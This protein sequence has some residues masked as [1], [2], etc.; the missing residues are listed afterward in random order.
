MENQTIQLL[1]THTMSF[2]RVGG[3]LS[4]KSIHNP[5][6]SFLDIHTMSYTCADEILERYRHFKI[7]KSKRTTVGHTY[8]VICFP[9][10]CFECLKITNAPIWQATG[11]SM[12]VQKHVL[13]TKFEATTKN[14]NTVFGH[15][16]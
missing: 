12:Y 15:I 3:T 10:V 7:K 2:E 13:E 16:Q 5:E 6:N 1:D 9:L 14:P 8:Y 4:Y 11:H